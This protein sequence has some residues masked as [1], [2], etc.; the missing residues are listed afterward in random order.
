M[1]RRVERR[2]PFGHLP[3]VLLQ[4]CGSWMV[5]KRQFVT[6]L[7]PSSFRGLRILRLSPGSGHRA[8]IHR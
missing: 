6:I 8:W 1:H 3:R 4:A 7:L 5:D 2:P